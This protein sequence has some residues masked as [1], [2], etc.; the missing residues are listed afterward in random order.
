MSTRKQRQKMPP[1]PTLYD[2]LMYQ[3]RLK[4]WPRELRK[5]LEIDERYH[6][7]LANSK[8]PDS[9]PSDL[10]EPLEPRR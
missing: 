2:E 9:E 6:R 1:A 5:W 4:T 7:S 3:M 8:D 10:S